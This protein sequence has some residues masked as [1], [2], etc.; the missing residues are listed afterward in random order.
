MAVIEEVDDDSDGLELEENP[1]EDEDGLELEENPGED[2]DEL[3]LE[4]NP[5][6]SDDDDGCAL[7]EN[8]EEEATGDE[9]PALETNVAQAPDLDDD[10]DS[11][12][13]VWEIPFATE[14]DAHEVPGC[15][16]IDIRL[17]RQNGERLGLVLDANNDIVALREGT[18]AARSGELL[19]GDSVIAVQGVA[20]SLGKRV[21][22]LLR[23]LPDAAT[24]IFTV[25]RAL[26]ATR[27]SQG[28]LAKDVIE[29]G[30]LMTPE[31]ATAQQEEEIK[32]RA[33]LRKEVE[34]LPNTDPRKAALQEQL[35][36]Q[37]L[38]ESKYMSAQHEPSAAQKK[39]MNDMW[40]RQARGGLDRRLSAA[41]MLKDEG[42]DKF[43]E[44]DYDAALEE[45]EYALNLFDYE[46]A[47]LCRDQEQAEL[48]DHK[49]GLSSDDLP[50]INAVRVPCLLNSAACH[51]KIKTKASLPKALE[52]C[53]LVLQAGPP[54][55]KRSKAHFRC[56]QAHFAL[57]NYREAWVALT[58]AQ[59]LNPSS[60]EVRALQ[61]Q[62]SYELKQLKVAERESREGL[63]TTE[64]NHKQLFRQE[65]LSYATKLGMLRQLLPEGGSKEER[66]LVAEVKLTRDAAEV[67]L[68]AVAAKGW[69]NLSGEQQMR[70]ASI[71]SAAQPRLGASAIRD[72]RDAGIFPPRDEERIFGAN[73]PQVLMPTP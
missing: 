25:R 41:E 53:A 70:F 62:V 50:R 27:G 22:Q 26:D 73:L 42:N 35:A 49:R 16:Q 72:G 46:M 29:H 33:K 31:E 32:A 36:P 65:K 17:T 45:Y 40:Y 52:C 11:D 15:Q 3:E 71:W 64:L 9:L 23:E 4:D 59:E 68:E 69:T 24:Y 6:E 38:A 63:M 8:E 58:Q 10:S 28:E 39:Q 12:D 1:G 43:S 48:G 66:K 2:E 54:A 60:R 5:G 21:A 56:G 67:L 7:E 18:P 47:N 14:D 34:A 30:P 13:E 55:D 19:V 57:E 61:A 20:C 37:N 51:I 44:G